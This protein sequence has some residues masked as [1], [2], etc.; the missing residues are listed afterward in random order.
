MAVRSPL[1]ISVL[2]TH[3]LFQIQYIERCQVAYSYRL[4]WCNKRMMLF[5]AL[6]LRLTTYA[7]GLTES[8]AYYNKENIRLISTLAI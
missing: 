7:L 6:V 5:P 4:Y 3:S 8:K 2:L 1:H